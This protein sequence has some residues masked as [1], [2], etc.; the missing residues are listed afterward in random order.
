[1]A[2]GGGGGGSTQKYIR[3]T[4]QV[5]G[6]RQHKNQQRPAN[7]LIKRSTVLITGL[8]H[9]SRSYISLKQPPL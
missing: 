2:G 6:V 5:E 7:R 3:I 1:M 9:Y 4:L 8:Q